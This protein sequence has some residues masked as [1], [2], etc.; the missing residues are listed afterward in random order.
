VPN[1]TG[2][3]RLMLML[4]CSA[5]GS[6]CVPTT[7]MAQ[8]KDCGPISDGCNGVLDCGTCHPPLSCSVYTPNVC[9]K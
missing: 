1:G 5:C 2:D 6:P 7:C 3:A 4:G 8:G 9:G